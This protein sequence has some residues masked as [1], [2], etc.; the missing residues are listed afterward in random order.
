MTGGMA[1]EALSHAGQISKNLIVILNDNQMSISRNTGAIS[2]Y[3]S[4]LTMS[5]HYQSLRYSI[6]RAV[7]RIPY[8]NKH[9]GKL[10]FRLKRGIKGLFLTN[11]LFVDLG[12]EYVGPL[13]GHD[14]HELE[15]VLR[16]VKRIP[17]PVVVHVVTTKGRG[18][19]PA[20]N[21]PAKFHGIGPFCISDG[22]VEKYDRLSFTQSFSNSLLELARARS[23]IVCITAAMASGTGLLPFAKKYPARFFDVGIAEEHAVTFAGGLAKGGLLPIICIYS[24]F[25]QRAIDQLIHDIAIPSAHI[26]LMLDRAGVV[27]A[28]GETHQGLFD[29]ALIRPIPHMT[30]FCPADAADLDNCL[31]WAVAAEGPVVI[32]YPKMTCPTDTGYFSGTI[33][34]GRGVLVPGSDFAPLLVHEESDPENRKVLFV[35]TGGM[36]SEVRT[37]SRSLLMKDIYTDIYALRFIK[38]LDEDYFIKTVSAY[39]AV[40]LVEDGVK[41]GGI[42]EYLEK[43]MYQNGLMNV[44]IKAFPDRFLE[45]GNREQICEDAGMSGSYLAAAALDLLKPVNLMVKNKLKKIEI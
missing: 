14:E 34:K 19:V 28:D 32:R 26:V 40:V 31:K 6:D 4:R 41:Q 18:Y 3:L 20:E 17:R 24:T 1:F 23:D 25:I 43:V 45:Q 16:R 12:F 22:T 15:V 9:L 21:D 37:A 39:D 29:I 2:R 42:C 36:Y 5:S 33:Q 38:P 44:T 11:N 13:N 10:I 27:P 8:L 30:I 7:D 35:C